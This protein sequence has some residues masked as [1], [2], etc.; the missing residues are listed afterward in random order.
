MKLSEK[1]AIEGYLFLTPWIAGVAIWIVI[2]IIS[3]FVLSFTKYE[4]LT[5]AKFVGFSNYQKLM[6]NPEFWQS[7]KVTVY[8]TSGA[9]PLNLICGLLLALL[10]NQKIKALSIIRTIYYMPAVI[11]GV[12]VSILWIWIFNPE[13]G[14]LNAILASFGIKGLGWVTSQTWVIPAFIIM[15]LWAVGGSMLLYLAGLQG[16]PTQLYEAAEIDGATAWHKFWKITLPMMTPVI[17]FN[18]IMGIIGS[19]QSFTYAFVMT[20]GGPA[21]ASLF[22]VLNLYNNAFLYF[23]MGYASALAWILFIILLLFVLLIFKS[24]PFWLYYRE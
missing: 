1:Q 21:D 10:L 2:P 8:Y 19:F 14:I 4:I 18:L 5:P 12:A 15:S 20:E 9:V 11:S 6:H 16:I 23:K 17:F 24:T 7:L 3:S 13:I 22:Y